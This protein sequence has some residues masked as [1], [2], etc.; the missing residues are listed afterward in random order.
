[1][2]AVR[3]LHVVG[4]AVIPVPTISSQCD[5]VGAAVVHALRIFS[6]VL[7]ERLNVSLP[8]RIYF[9]TMQCAP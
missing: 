8:S 1:M 5:S 4:R 3:V 9:L 7:S 2:G 6:A